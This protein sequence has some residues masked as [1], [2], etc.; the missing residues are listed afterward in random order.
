MK[1]SLFCFEP[2]SGTLRLPQFGGDGW[3]DHGFGTRLAP[4]ASWPPPAGAYANLR[5]IHSTTVTTVTPDCELGEGDALVTAE[6]GRWIGVRTAD[7]VPILMADPVRRAVAAVH[8][9]WRGTAGDIAQKTV[10]RLSEEFGTRAADVT[11]AIGP[12]IGACCYEVG[13]EVARVFPGRCK[14]PST[15]GGKPHL[16]LAGVLRDQLLRAGILARNLIHVNLC[17]RCD[18]SLFH[19]FRRDGAAA[20]RLI[21]AIRICDGSGGTR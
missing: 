12:A 1:S 21:S 13:Q 9:G 2:G 20:G 14:S 10:A 15:P 8:S 19:S 16:D 3:F 6:S 7:C 11:V 18:A 17:T 5:Q 4:A